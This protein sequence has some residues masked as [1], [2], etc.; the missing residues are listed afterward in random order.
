MRTPNL[1][2]A[3]DKIFV[4][5]WVS[6]FRA[7]FDVNIWKAAWEACV[8]FGYQFGMSKYYLKMYSVPQ[9][10]HKTSPLQISRHLQRRHV[11]FRKI[12]E[13]VNRYLAGQGNLQTVLNQLNPFHSLAISYPIN[14]SILD[15]H[16]YQQSLPLRFS[17]QNFACIYY[18]TYACYITRRSKPPYVNSTS[19]KTK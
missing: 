6:C 1:N 10:K 13:T 4:S 8:E 5:T 3:F 17:D 12:C 14:T 15:S 9:R 2:T 19:N 18:F 16:L 7:N 11:S